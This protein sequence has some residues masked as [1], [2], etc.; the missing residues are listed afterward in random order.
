MWET[1][2]CRLFT[3][4]ERGVETRVECSTLRTLS[5]D[6]DKREQEKGKFTSKERR[7]EGTDSLDLGFK[8][9]DEVSS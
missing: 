9:M 2:G 4:Q 8:Q 7:E 5:R 1:C 6:Y 3:S